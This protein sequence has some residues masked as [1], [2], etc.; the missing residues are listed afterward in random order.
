MTM[1]ITPRDLPIELR[2]KAIVASVS[3]KGALSW[4]GGSYQD[5]V[6]RTRLRAFG[7]YAITVDETAP[8]IRPLNI[9][10]NK[11][12]AGSSQIRI[13]IRDNLSGIKSYSGRVD[14]EWVL[15]EYDSKNALLTHRFDGRIGPGNHELVMTVVDNKNNSATLSIPFKR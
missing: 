11:N 14:G 1:E 9:S 2:D 7:N 8:S 4:A 10:A 15:F 13:R 3:S 6:V 5:G 12:M